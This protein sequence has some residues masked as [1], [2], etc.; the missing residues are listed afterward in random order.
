MFPTSGCGTCPPN[1]I[2]AVTFP[3]RSAPIGWSTSKPPQTRG[4]TTP[5][6]IRGRRRNDDNGLRGAC[7]GG[8]PELRMSVA[9]AAPRSRDG[10]RPEAVARRSLR[11]PQ[12]YPFRGRSITISPSRRPEAVPHDPR[13]GARA[14]RRRRGDRSRSRPRLRDKRPLTVIRPRVAWSAKRSIVIGREQPSNPPPPLPAPGR[15]GSGLGQPCV[16]LWCRAATSSD[17]DDLDRS[18]LGEVSVLRDNS[19]PVTHGC[20]RDP[21]V[22]PS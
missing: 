7:Q 19:G 17:V 4:L 18:E 22:V 8:V 6:P 5:F 3:E 9:E 10:L 20:G 12:R 2:F 11:R 16:P 13:T 21:G 15:Y 1:G 14:P